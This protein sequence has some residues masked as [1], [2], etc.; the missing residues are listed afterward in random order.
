MGKESS[1]KQWNGLLE[2]WTNFFL[3]KSFIQVIFNHVA[4]SR[5]KIQI[6]IIINTGLV[7]C[8]VLQDY[9]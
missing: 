4:K 8:M 7:K 9:L 6:H 1:Y 2:W 3:K 5:D